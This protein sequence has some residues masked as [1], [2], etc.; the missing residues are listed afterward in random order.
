MPDTGSGV[1]T[2]KSGVKPPT[3]PWRPE[4]AAEPSLAGD[5]DQA[6]AYQGRELSR[7]FNLSRNP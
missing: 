6:F 2:A 4:I 7:A 3:T 1:S 5:L